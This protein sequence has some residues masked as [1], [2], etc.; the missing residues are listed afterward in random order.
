MIE[1]R[2]PL[3]RI[4]WVDSN[5]WNGW[6]DTHTNIDNEALRCVSVGWLVR[7]TKASKAITA[8]LADGDPG[9]MHGIMQ[10]PCRAI[11]RITHLKL[12]K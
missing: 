8:H 11:T 12:P 9:Q 3:V 1:K 4:E 7:S 5:G 2:Y 10:I 6:I